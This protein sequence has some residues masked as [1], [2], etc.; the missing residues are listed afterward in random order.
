VE[1]ETQILEETAVLIPILEVTTT[2][3]QEVTTT[4]KLEVTTTPK[5]E[6]T[7]TPKLEVTTTPKLEAI[8][9]PKLEATTITREA[10]THLQTTV[11]RVEALDQEKVRLTLPQVV[12]LI[13]DLR[14]PL[15]DQ[16]ILR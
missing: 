12:L 9:T 7:T 6:V 11:L 14:L 1:T 16:E 15:E 8:T 10:I 3:K 4:P 2:H 13:L 5:L